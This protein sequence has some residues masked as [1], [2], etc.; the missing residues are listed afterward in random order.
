MYRGPSIVNGLSVVAAPKKGGSK[1]NTKLIKG[2]SIGRKHINLV[3]KSKKGGVEMPN[4]AEVIAERSLLAKE[5]VQKGNHLRFCASQHLL[6]T[7]AALIVGIRVWSYEALMKSIEAERGSVPVPG[8]DRK[9]SPVDAGSIVAYQTNASVYE[10]GSRYGAC[11]P[12]AGVFP[13]L[14]ALGQPA[15]LSE[16]IQAMA[17]GYEAMVCIASLG[18]PLFTQRGFH[19]TG[20][21]APFGAAAAAG[22]LL[23]FDKERMIAALTLSSS[24]SCGLMHAFQEETTQPLHV[25]HAVRAGLIAAL[26]AKQGFSGDTSILERGFFPAYLGHAPHVNSIDYRYFGDRWAI[27]NAYLKPYPGCRHLHPALDAMDQLLTQHDIPSQ[28][29]DSIKVET[30]RVAIETEIHQIRSRGDAYF[31]LP[32][33]LSVRIILG[34]ADWDAFDVRHLEN[35]KVKGLINKI[36]VCIDEEIDKAY[37]NKRGA[38]VTLTLKS[39]EI[40]SAFQPLPRGEPELPVSFKE[41]ADKFRRE[42]QGYLGKEDIDKIITKLQGAEG[43]AGEIF[44]ILAKPFHREEN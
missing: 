33:A 7:L 10:D 1:S 36:N 25:S 5:A 3:K 27:E 4:F 14:W 32:Y 6:D 22:I 2:E 23:K 37:P 19:P 31:N 17:G 34:R 16:L 30:Y 13:A 8:T 44:K 11:H 43:Q 38:R 18:N 9:T 28:E 24:G 40:F 26:M 29:I 39:G 20:I 41:T 15:T 35:P 21:C 42:A 12:A